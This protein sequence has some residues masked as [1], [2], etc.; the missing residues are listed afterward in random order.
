MNAAFSS[1][2]FS[3]FL[4]AH[5]SQDEWAVFFEPKDLVIQPAMKY[6]IL[7]CAYSVLIFAA[8]I[9]PFDPSIFEPNG[10]GKTLPLFFQATY[11]YSW[12]APAIP[13]FIGGLV[14]LGLPSIP[15]SLARCI[16]VFSIVSGLL[17][18]L[19]GMVPSLGS[20]TQILH[21]VTLTIAVAASFLIWSGS[22]GQPQ[23]SRAAKIGI[24]IGT[25][26]ALWSL[27]TVPMILVQARFIAD[28]A[29]YC[30]AEHS[31]NAPIEAVRDLRGFSFYT[32][33]TGDKSTSKWYFHGLMLVDHPDGQ[34]VYNWSPGR[35]R[36]DP[37]ER[38]DAMIEPVR[39]VCA[40]S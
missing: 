1:V 8:Y 29:P 10:R 11:L 12:L 32:T 33:A 20:D 16:A 9:E 5:P 22:G 6:K 15:R 24:S 38:P 7:F 2:T 36:F 17:L 14:L 34:R 23:P 25:I 40:P 26:A 39:N 19:F 28:G 35:W 18:T 13:A 3:S 31:K 37:V 21:G 4:A 30:I 27:L